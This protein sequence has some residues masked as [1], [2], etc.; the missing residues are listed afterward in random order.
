MFELTDIGANLT[1]E[2]F[3]PD[4][5][6]VIAAAAAV[7]VNQLII[8]GASETESQQAAKLAAAYP[9]RLWSTAGVHPHLA[10]EWGP[11][12]GQTLRELATRPQVI[13]IGECGLDFNRDFSP[14]DVQRQV[15]AAHLDL[16]AELKMPLFMHQR[17]AHSDFMAQFAPRRDEF[18]TAVLHCFTDTGDAL[19]DYMDLDLYIG[20]TG[21]ICDERRGLALREL[22]RDIPIDRLL[23]ETDAPYLLPRDLRPKPKTRRNEPKWLPHIL[24]VVADCRGD[25]PA[26]LA[27]ATHANAAACFGL[28]KTLAAKLGT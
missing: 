9:E 7:G 26:E 5:D 11:N 15:F 3:A 23:I 12:T 25:D 22:V 18:T 21:W 2:S 4:R 10:K 28:P 20:I 27:A 6:Q 16:A 1:H 19:Q 13:A 14:R 8:T 17:D 24:D